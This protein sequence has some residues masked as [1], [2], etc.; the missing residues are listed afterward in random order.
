MQL[1]KSMAENGHGT[2]LNRDSEAPNFSN[3]I[4]QRA[5]IDFSSME[6]S[7]TAAQNDVELANME[8][9]MPRMSAA[10]LQE[11]LL[12]KHQSSAANR[13]GLP[14]F[15]GAYHNVIPSTSAMSSGQHS[16]LKQHKEP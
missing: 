16:G 3:Q 12:D 6:S 5:Q 11:E 7:K 10:L 8:S 13:R 1:Q 15:I 14:S 4:I 9:P 2:R